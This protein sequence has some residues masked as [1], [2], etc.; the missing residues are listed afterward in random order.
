M[1]P[2]PGNVCRPGEA[3]LIWPHLEMPARRAFLGLGS[4]LGDRERTLA[5][6]RERLRA[7]GFAIVRQSALYWTEPV[8][9]PPQEW[10]LN[11]VLEGA[12]TLAP[13]QLLELALRVE[14]EQGR[15]RRE[16]NGPRTLDVDLLLY[17]D[18]RRCAP[19]LELPHP[20]LPER[21]FVLVPLC[22]IAPEVVHPGL[23]LS[24]RQLLERCPDRSAVERFVAVP[25]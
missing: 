23:G 17:D 7:G 10:F 25:R 15:E 22:E 16:R 9:G 5:E 3:R 11:Q 8:G 2:A 4:N 14:R 21:R 1:P 24:A 19:G 20:R 12:T 6:A 13:E 18:E